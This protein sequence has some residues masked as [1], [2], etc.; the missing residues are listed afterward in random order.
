KLK[1]RIKSLGR[2]S[3]L[4]GYELRAVGWSQ[5]RQRVYFQWKQPADP[6]EKDYDTYVVSRDGAGL[7]KL[8]EEEAKNAPP[9]GGELSR[10]KKTTVFVDNGDIFIYDHQAGQ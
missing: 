9:L 1:V 3:W 8:T 2:G 10:D 7:R 6:R 4:C 5:D